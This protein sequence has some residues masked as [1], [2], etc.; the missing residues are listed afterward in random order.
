M[1]TQLVL[2]MENIVLVA[3]VLTIA[4]LTSLVSSDGALFSNSW[5]VEIKGGP[6]VA[7][8]LARKHGFANRGQVSVCVLSACPFSYCGVT[9]FVCLC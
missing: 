7:D 3:G 2:V 8:M 5:A 1:M 4:C 9:S 6:D